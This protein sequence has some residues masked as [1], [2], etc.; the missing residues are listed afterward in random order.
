ME[1]EQRE[2]SSV[3]TRW[4]RYPI[5]NPPNSDGAV[6]PS[7]PSS[8]IFCHIS[9]GNS[10][11]SVVGPSMGRICSSANRCTAALISPIVPSLSKGA[12]I[13]APLP[14]IKLPLIP[15]RKL[16][17]NGG[18]K[19][20]KKGECLAQFGVLSWE[21]GFSSPQPN[22]FFFRRMRASAPNP[23]TATLAGSGTGLK[24]RSS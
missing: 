4:A 21:S 20:M 12:K 8:P 16:T 22:Y 3:M 23:I 5:S 24:C 11:A 10:P 13:S 17:V 1:P 15:L 6:T 9:R 14:T 19:P 7:K 2:I 18:S